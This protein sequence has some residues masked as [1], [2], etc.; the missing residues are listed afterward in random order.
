MHYTDVTLL[1]TLNYLC[2]YMYYTACYTTFLPSPK[3]W[4]VYKRGSSKE[5]EEN[6]GTSKKLAQRF[7]ITD[8]V[9]EGDIPLCLPGTGFTGGYI[10]ETHTTMHE[11]KKDG[12]VT[13]LV[14]LCY[15]PL[16]RSSVLLL[17]EYTCITWS[18]V[19]NVG[20]QRQ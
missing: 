15:D 13:C 19:R 9:E 4:A 11:D 2:N 1:A 8:D 12:C 7:N 16:V 3:K 17:D 14:P 18:Y 6:V 10:G 20:S 5:A